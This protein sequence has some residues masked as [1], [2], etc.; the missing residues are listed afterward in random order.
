MVRECGMYAAIE[1]YLFVKMCCF[2]QPA[3]RKRP[4]MSSRTV[5]SP[6]SLQVSLYTVGSHLSLLC[7]SQYLL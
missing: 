1:N 3:K 4:P 5:G 6:R 7:N 2:N